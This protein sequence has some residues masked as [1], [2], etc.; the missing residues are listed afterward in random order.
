MSCGGLIVDARRVERRK[1]VLLKVKTA[2]GKHVRVG[3]LVDCASGRRYLPV[4]L[5]TGGAGR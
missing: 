5:S 4:L 2:N 1:G 3:R